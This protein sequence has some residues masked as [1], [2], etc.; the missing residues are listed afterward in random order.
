MQ[1]NISRTPPNPIKFSELN[2]GQA[3][4]FENEMDIEPFEV[5]IKTDIVGF[6]D[7]NGSVFWDNRGY[8]KVYPVTFVTTTVRFK[9]LT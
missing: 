7:G 6:T 9:Q 2:C 3:F 8:K 1:A 4:I 5:Y